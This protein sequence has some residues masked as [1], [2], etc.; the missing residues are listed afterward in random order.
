MKPLDHLGS[1]APY[2]SDREMRTYVQETN[3][4]FE[5]QALL[6]PKNRRMIEHLE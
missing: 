1:N 6:V 4:T 3:E 5:A 2:T